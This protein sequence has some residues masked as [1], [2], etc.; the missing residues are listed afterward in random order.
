[1]ELPTYPK[2]RL[3]PHGDEA[4]SELMLKLSVRTLLGAGVFR[5]WRGQCALFDAVGVWEA[6]AK[7][8]GFQVLIS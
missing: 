2:F 5:K 1:M 4:Q 7:G 8:R 3:L 6:L